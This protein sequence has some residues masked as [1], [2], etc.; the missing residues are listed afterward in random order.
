MSQNMIYA[1]YLWLDGKQP[2]QELRS[3]TR[4]LP[5]A[6]NTTPTLSSFPNWSFDGSS[7]YQAQGSQSDLI[8]K[9][10]C[11]CKDLL[12]GD[13]SY[14][15][16]CEVF[17]PNGNPHPSNHRKHLRSLMAKKEIAQQEIWMGFEQEYTFFKNS[18]PLG[19]PK[20]GTPL[21]QG[22]YYCGV[23]VNKVFGRSIVEEHLKLCQQAGLYLYGINAEVMPGQ[24]E[25]Q[26]GHR[27]QHTEISDPLTVSDHLWI[28]R[29]I[30]FRVAENSRVTVSLD[31]KPV[32]GDWNG[33]G[34]H[35]NFS[36]K[37]MREPGAGIKHIQEAIDHLS[38]CHKEHIAV[39][40][41]ALEK[42]LTGLHETCSIDEFKYGISHRGAS[43]RI[44]AH[45]QKT[46][47]GYFEDRRPGANANP[48]RIAS[49]LI[50]TVCLPNSVAVKKKMMKT[51]RAEAVTQ[52]NY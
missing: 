49:R 20:K 39:Y 50:Q 35:T 34:M 6:T 10:V 31:N 12:R 5:F 23:G 1:E 2:T 43:I 48:Y 16:L 40:G 32:R 29:W 13:T 24:W 36:T 33:A 52:T 37:S 3:K 17:L 27:N 46:G 7:T 21:P 14:I 47:C 51:T 42:R 44:P 28:A 22:P 38:K 15:V 18:R 8:L 4:L 25:F 11:F 41:E 9:P 30:L 45:V 26:I 19:W